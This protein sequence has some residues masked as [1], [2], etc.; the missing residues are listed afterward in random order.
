MDPRQALSTTRA[1]RRARPGPIPLE[2][3]ER[4]LDAAIRAST[5]GNAQHDPAGGSGFPAVKSVMPAARTQGGRGSLTSVFGA[6]RGEE[7]REFL[8]VP[9]EEGWGKA[10]RESF[11]YP[12]DRCG[13]AGRSDP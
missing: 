6:F 4:I 2:A 9:G 3:R 5:G 8:A 13:S 1:M 12:V 11:G 7:T 10:C